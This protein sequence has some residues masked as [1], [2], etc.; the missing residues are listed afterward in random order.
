MDTGGIVLESWI[1]ETE[2]RRIIKMQPNLK[3]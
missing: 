3:V 2:R 1:T